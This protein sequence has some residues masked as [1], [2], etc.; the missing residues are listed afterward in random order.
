[1]TLQPQLS[2]DAG[3]RLHNKSSLPQQVQNAAV[4]TAKGVFL[5]AS[6]TS[7]P[8]VSCQKSGKKEPTQNTHKTSCLLQKKMLA[9]N[10]NSYF[11][12][13]MTTRT[14]SAHVNS[15]GGSICQERYLFWIIHLVSQLINSKDLAITCR[16]WFFK[17]FNC[18][19]KRWNSLSHFE[20]ETEIIARNNKKHSIKRPID[21]RTGRELTWLNKI[22]GGIAIAAVT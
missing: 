22:H 13:T 14:W 15:A 19:Y 5:K 1:M 18:G 11:I 6:W 7:K 8:K 17:L 12:Q 21:P 10:S 4:C 9:E 3:P 2:W 16:L 20:A